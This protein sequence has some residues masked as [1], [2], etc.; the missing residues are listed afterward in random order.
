MKDL[1]RYL[2][3]IVEP[4]V[5]EFD[6]NPDSVRLAF[7]AC[8]AVFHSID[9][10]AHP[11]PSRGLRQRFRKKCSEFEIVDSVAHAFKHV[12]SGNPRGEHLKSTDV[13]ARPPAA[14]DFLG[15]YTHFSIGRIE[16]YVG[17]V[18]LDTNREVN[19]LQSVKAVVAFLRKLSLSDCT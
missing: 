17:G 6:K 13:V 4:T 10:L 14:Y 12:V 15:E 5:S 1:E 7:L 18:T 9:Y 16:D 8:V 2:E 19:V 3:E 11:R